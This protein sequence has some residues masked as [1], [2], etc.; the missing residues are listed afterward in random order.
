MLWLHTQSINN[1]TGEPALHATAWDEHPGHH[2]LYKIGIQPQVEMVDGQKSWYPSFELEFT[3]SDFLTLHV[4]LLKFKQLHQNYL[5]RQVTEASTTTL[6][7][8]SGGLC[9]ELDYTLAK[10]NKA[11]DEDHLTPECRALKVF[12]MA[13]GQRTNIGTF[14]MFGAVTGMTGLLLEAERINAILNGDAP[15]AVGAIERMPFTRPAL[16]TRPALRVV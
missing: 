12:H 16:N 10:R 1:I 5:A 9:F 11:G 6:T 8:L 3:L 15:E 7:E 14:K 2:F 13:S 4:L